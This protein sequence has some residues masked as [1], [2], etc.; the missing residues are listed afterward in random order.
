[1]NLDKTLLFKILEQPAAPYR[2]THVQKVIETTFD[3]AG[4]PYFVDPIG[5]IVVGA[6][7]REEYVAKLKQK[8]REPVRLF[9]AHMDHP[10][11]HG[12]KW[13]SKNTLAVQWHGGS[14]LKRLAGS[15]VWISTD[16]GWGKAKASFGTAVLSKAKLSKTARPHMVSGEVKFKLSDLQPRPAATDIYGGFA[17]RKP[18]WQQGRVLYTKAA[19]DLVGSFVIVTLALR[20]LSRGRKDPNFLGLLTRAEEVGYVGCIGHFDLGWQKRATRKLVC[21]SLETSRTLPG[22]VIGKG[23][24]VR[25]GDRRTVFDPHALKIFRDVA[26]KVLPGKHQARVMDGGTCEGTVAVANGLSAVGISVPLGN[27]HNQSFQGG[28][29]S[30]GPDAPA[31][32]FVHLDDIAGVLALAEGLMQKGLPWHDPWGQYYK[33]IRK[34]FTDNKKLLGI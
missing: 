31:P 18:V 5:N 4:V 23:P 25:L 16:R 11:F 24:V 8:S 1:M 21:V 27:Y 6:R 9:I 12:V 29:D 33:T 26:D 20:R 30:R 17:F 2:E 19:D 7:N 3:R 32:E 10:G 15:K 13:T 28:P 22:A 34:T 14:P